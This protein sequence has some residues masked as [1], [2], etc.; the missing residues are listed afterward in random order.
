MRKFFPLR[1]NGTGF[2]RGFLYDFAR[3]CRRSLRSHC[4]LC[5]G[6]GQCPFRNSQQPLRW[7]QNSP[8]SGTLRRGQAPALLYYNRHFP[9][10]GNHPALP[11]KLYFLRVGNGLDRSA[12][13]PIHWGGG[14]RKARDGG[15]NYIKING[16]AR[17]PAPTTGR[18]VTATPL[19]LCR[20]ATFPLTGESHRP[21]RTK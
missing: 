19:P 1:G 21:L 5:V 16:R 17:R 4:F 14:A 18:R 2:R 20:Y 11:C 10:Q 8:N 3:L 7:E 15:A 9:Y 6:N 13:L 12:N